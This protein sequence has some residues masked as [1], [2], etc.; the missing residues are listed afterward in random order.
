M[1]TI[2]LQILHYLWI[3]RKNIYSIF[4]ELQKNRNIHLDWKITFQEFQEYVK[5][6][7]NSWL[8]V[9][10]T[11]LDDEKIITWD[12][13]NNNLQ[14]NTSKRLILNQQKGV[15][16]VPTS[17]IRMINYNTDIVID[18]YKKDTYIAELKR[19][20]ILTK[21]GSSV[22]KV[23]NYLKKKIQQEFGVELVYF[24]VPYWSSKYKELLEKNYAHS[25]GG[26][27][28]NEYLYDFRKDWD[29]DINQYTFK[30]K[31]KYHH[32]F[33]NLPK[34][35]A[36]KRNWNI[37]ENYIH[38][39]WIRDIYYNNYITDFANHWVFFWYWYFFVE[40]KLVN[41]KKLVE[42]KNKIKVWEYRKLAWPTVI[43]K[44]DKFIETIR[45]WTPDEAIA[46]LQIIS[47]RIQNQDKI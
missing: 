2:L 44:P 39:L 1:K 29:I 15:E 25:L 37:V 35:E 3:R 4:L 12:I 45:K 46:C 21:K 30:E 8:N 17:L 20:W 5:I 28:S 34:E 6:F 14:E 27:I 16:C 22:K 23:S 13:L 38:K 42:E 18:N 40:K 26:W 31:I 9:E 41:E 33:M 47:Q 36:E 10:E 7:E 11:K 32:L 24:K 43:N 19:L